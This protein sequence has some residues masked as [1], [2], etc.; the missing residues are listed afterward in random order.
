MKLGCNAWKNRGDSVAVTDLR[1]RTLHE[2]RKSEKRGVLI[3]DF[4]VHDF[5]VRKF[6]AEQCESLIRR[7]SLPLRENRNEWTSCRILALQRRIENLRKQETP[8]Q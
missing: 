3:N 4:D 8:T 5:I 6:N 7:Y 2:I 1:P